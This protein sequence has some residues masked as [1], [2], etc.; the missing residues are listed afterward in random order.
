MSVC[1]NHLKGNFEYKNSDEIYI[2]NSLFFV[3]FL[4]TS[5]S[6][7]CVNC[8]FDEKNLANITFKDQNL[9]YASFK[10]A[11]LVNADFT[12]ANLKG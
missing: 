7:D 9:S 1:E 12:G 6:A 8:N 2:I 3:G 11:Y 10:G 4:I 5:A